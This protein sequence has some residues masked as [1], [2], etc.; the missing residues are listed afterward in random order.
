MREN[1]FFY[2]LKIA[3]FNLFYILYLK[4]I[5]DIYLEFVL[6]F[7]ELCQIFYLT[8]NFTVKY[9]IIIIIKFILV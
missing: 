8:M 3:L 7:I 6:T 2:K 9:Y 1:S 5:P 4:Y